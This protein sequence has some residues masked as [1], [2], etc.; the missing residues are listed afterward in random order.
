M[1]WTRR[2]AFSVYRGNGH[3]RV[4]HTR[5]SCIWRRFVTV[6]S[7]VCPGLSSILLIMHFTCIPKQVLLCPV[8]Q[9]RTLHPQ[10][11][12]NSFKYIF[13]LVFYGFLKKVRGSRAVAQPAWGARGTAPPDDPDCPPRT[14]RYWSVPPYKNRPYTF[15]KDHLI[16]HNISINYCKQV[17]FNPCALDSNVITDST[18]N[19]IR[20]IAL[21]IN[22]VL[23]A[24]LVGHAFSSPIK[25]AQS[26]IYGFT[27]AY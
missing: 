11:S 17:L 19:G 6:F 26:D 20:V 23:S 12:R 1:T 13:I 15:L 7:H 18:T 14:V 16:I 21:N 3:R 8:L 24:I 9:W 27:N 10:K 2:H 4:N 25:C 5:L 22:Q